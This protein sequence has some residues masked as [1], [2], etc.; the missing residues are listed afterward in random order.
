MQALTRSSH[1]A[2]SL[3]LL[4]ST[5]LLGCQNKTA[6][7]P[8]PPPDV[9]TATAFQQDVPII[10]EWVAITDGYINAQITP[11]VTGYLIRQNYREGSFVHKDD[12]LFEIDPRPFQAILEQTEA[13][14]A[15]A[16]A[17]LGKAN[18]DVQRD[19][20]LAQQRAIAQA[21]LDTEIQT[22]L[23]ADATVQA[24]KAQVDQAKLNV[25]FTK[26]RSLT[27]GVSGIAKGQLGDLVGP[28]TVL[29]T[30]SQVN[31]IKAFIAIS[32]QEYLKFAVLI[33]RNALNPNPTSSDKPVPRLILGDGTLYPPI[34]E[35][36]FTNREVDA[37]T[38]TI[39]IAA[40]FANPQNIL[41]PGQFCKIQAVTD[42]RKDA[43]LIP[44]KAI[45]E[46][47]NLYQVA[48]VD[49]SNKVT[50]RNIQVGDRYKEFWIVNGGLKP[51]ERVITMGFQKTRDG[52]MVKV[53]GNFTP[54]PE[55]SPTPSTAA[56]KS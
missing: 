30:V 56:G 53:T 5:F 3:I 48:V 19:T 45:N 39:R 37:G 24:A 42:I 21:Q 51:G 10:S 46:L 23:A 16:R 27:D 43:I 1:L 6:A 35:F 31:P 34:G 33:N 15:E 8:P 38:G 52:S 9:E 44:A 12:V 22:A 18:L 50:I 28:T 2:L 36:I 13:H 11:Q 7:G 55:Q 20:P 14:L 26:V 4:A 49:S 25:G 32:E 54:A 41:R 17:Q 47:Q 40:A 29:T